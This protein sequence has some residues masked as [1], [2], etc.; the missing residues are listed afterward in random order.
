MQVL[1]GSLGRL[2]QAINDPSQ[3]VIP[4]RTGS[5]QYWHAFSHHALFPD[6]IRFSV[7]SPTPSGH[8]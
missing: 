8:I 3:K 1:S 5:Q 6:H 4:G 7:V 2:A